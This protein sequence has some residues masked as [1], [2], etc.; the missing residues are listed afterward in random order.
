MKMIAHRG[1]TTR[2]HENTMEAFQ[3][4]Y[5]AGAYGIELDVRLTKDRIPVIHHHMRLN[6]DAESG[7]VE[8]YTY[9]EI[10]SFQTTVD[11]ITYQI[12]CLADVLSTFCGKLYLELHIQSYDREIIHVVGELLNRYPQYHNKMEI[13]SYEP[14]ILLGFSEVCPGIRRDL[15]FFREGWMTDEMMIRLMIEKANLGSAVGVHIPAKYITASVIERFRKIGLDV[16]CGLINKQELYEQVRS[17]DIKIFSTDH[18]HLFL[19]D[20]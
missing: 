8:D 6:T 9:Q 2:A 20:S 13:T 12:P 15:L 10:Q 3:L 1:D 5:E 16:H 18:I 14:A 19:N 17:A 4:A 11:G 7:F